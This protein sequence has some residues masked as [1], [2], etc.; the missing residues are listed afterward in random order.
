M[1]DSRTVA[2][3]TEQT[4]LLYAIVFLTGLAGMTQFSWW[5]A[6]AGGCILSLK[7]MTEEWAASNSGVVLWDVSQITSNLAI[8]T[9]ASI[10]AFG[11]GRTIAVLWGL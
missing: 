3:S 9:V 1:R 8:S 7:L 10:V 2:N 11:A 5:A 4:L 6:A